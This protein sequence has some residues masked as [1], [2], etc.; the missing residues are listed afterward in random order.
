MIVNHKIS[1]YPKF[2]EK[3][4]NHGYGSSFWGINAGTKNPTR[5]GGFQEWWYPKN[6]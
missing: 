1:G 6:G 2:S 4:M 5:C 3:I